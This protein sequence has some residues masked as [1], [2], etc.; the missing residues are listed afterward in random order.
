MWGTVNSHRGTV[1]IDESLQESSIVAIITISSGS[2]ACCNARHQ[3][4]SSNSKIATSFL[5]YHRTMAAYQIIPAADGESC[6]IHVCLL[7]SIAASALEY[8]E[9]PLIST[10]YSCYCWG[11]SHVIILFDLH[12]NEYLFVSYDFNVLN[13]HF[14]LIN[15]EFNISVILWTALVFRVP[16]FWKV[17]RRIIS[18]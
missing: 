15:F 10:L 7:R 16:Y 18:C 1:D 13:V 3:G 8:S 14:I 5:W 11:Y 9:V 4:T 17:C 12:K 2:V 6:R